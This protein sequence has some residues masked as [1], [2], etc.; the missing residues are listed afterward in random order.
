MYTQRVSPDRASLDL[1]KLDQATGN[2]N[3]KVGNIE[4]E[5]RY[6]FRLRFELDRFEP[7]T[8]ELLAVRL[9]YDVYNNG[10]KSAQSQEV[11]LDVNFVAVKP[12]TG[13]AEET[14][15]E[16]LVPDDGAD[17]APTTE[18][19]AVLADKDNGEDDE[20]DE[21]DADGILCETGAV[22]QI[23]LGGEPI[24]ETGEF[25]ASS[26]GIVVE[27]FDLREQAAARPEVTGRRRFD[28]VLIDAGENP[29][30]LMREIRD[31]IDVDVHRAADMIRRT[32]TVVT[33]LADESEAESLLDRLAA[34]GARAEVRANEAAAPDE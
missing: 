33:T 32:N 24:E 2:L 23:E 26:D 22:E 7:G 9:D 5:N 20:D 34:V 4:D 25:E 21:L 14:V 31:A 10:L 8:T 17:V 27:E 6:E 15:D 1:S 19:A 12:A 11:S 29:I 18:D 28:L 30:R 3:L 16:A 13:P